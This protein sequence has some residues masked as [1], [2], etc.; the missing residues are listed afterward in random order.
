MCIVKGLRDVISLASEL[1]NIGTINGELITMP[2]VRRMLET[3]G[4][5][6][7]AL[8]N[9]PLSASRQLRAPDAAADQSRCAR[10]ENLRTHALNITLP[11]CSLRGSALSLLRDESSSQNSLGANRIF[12]LQ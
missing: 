6:G 12:V 2:K 1:D 9:T 3:M 11:H 7:A 10:Q 8:I 5:V 4:Y